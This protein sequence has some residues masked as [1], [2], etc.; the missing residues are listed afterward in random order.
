MWLPGYQMSNLY[1]W[2]LTHKG[3]GGLILV[4]STCVILHGPLGKSAPGWG[5]C[6]CVNPSSTGNGADNR[7]L[8]RQ[9]CCM[10]FNAGGAGGLSEAGTNEDRHS[11][12]WYENGTP[13]SRTCWLSYDHLFFLEA[14]SGT[15]RLIKL[16]FLHTIADL[17]H[18]DLTS[19]LTSLDL[20][21]ELAFRPV[22][23]FVF[24]T[25]HCI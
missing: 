25:V 18:V 4:L 14:V 24:N 23:M 7:L 15:N 19:N 2:L 12:L 17:T 8:R 13:F 22:C 1:S 10:W 9:Q 6:V 21:S 16:L 3:S 20:T 5:M 11:S